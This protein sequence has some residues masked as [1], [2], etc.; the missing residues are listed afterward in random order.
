MNAFIELAAQSGT[1]ISTT[2]LRDRPQVQ[3]FV[4]QAEA[5]ISSARTHVI[6]SVGA[7]WTAACARDKD[8]D[9]E[10]A[11]A[12][13]TITRAMWESVKAVDIL[14]DAAGTNAIHQR[15]LL[16]RNFRDIHVAVQHGAGLLSNFES[17]GQAVLG[18]RPPAPGW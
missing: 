18:L 16:E 15:F 10:V 7:V 3:S 1:T 11:Q 4:G 12:R 5:I 17:G 8:I 2:V 14:F 6:N 9:A 13:L